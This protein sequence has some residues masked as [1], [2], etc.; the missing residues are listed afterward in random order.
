MGKENAQLEYDN[1]MEL[2]RKQTESKD[3]H[4]SED[5]KFYVEQ[6]EKVKKLLE[7]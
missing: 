7:A 6:L 4:I 1:I 3:E 5:A 2:F